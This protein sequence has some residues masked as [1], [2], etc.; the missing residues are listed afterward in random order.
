[1]EKAEDKTKEMRKALEELAGKAREACWQEITGVL[2][3]HKFNL[4]ASA[5][6]RSDGRAIHQFE[7]I[8]K[9]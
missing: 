9:Q 7:L 4:G 8:P 6:I 2:E 1:M 5:I 3:K